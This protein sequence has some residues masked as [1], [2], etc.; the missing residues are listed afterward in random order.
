[1]LH[2]RK[3][4]QDTVRPL[5]VSHWSDWENPTES[6]Q[7]NRFQMSHAWTG[8]RDASAVLSIPYALDWMGRLHPEGWAGLQQENTRRARAFRLTVR[9]FQ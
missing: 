1:M 4:R 5:I 9:D 7:Y 6:P 2:V 3:D 8:T